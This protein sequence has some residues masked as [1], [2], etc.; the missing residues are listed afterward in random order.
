MIQGLK[1]LPLGDLSIRG[2]LE[3]LSNYAKAATALETKPRNEIYSDRPVNKSL[4]DGTVA[5]SPTI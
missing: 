3:G 2:K 4:Q 5:G 1:H